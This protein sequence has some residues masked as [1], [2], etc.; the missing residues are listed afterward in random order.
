M[1]LQKTRVTFAN[2]ECHSLFYLCEFIIWNIYRVSLQM[3]Y[4]DTYRQL[5]T[6]CR[7]DCIILWNG[8]PS[9]FWDPKW[10]F[11][12]GNGRANIAASH[13][14]CFAPQS[15]SNPL[16]HMATWLH[17]SAH[18]NHALYFSKRLSRNL[19][20]NPLLHTNI[21]ARNGAVAACA[22]PRVL[23]HHKHLELHLSHHRCSYLNF[24]CSQRSNAD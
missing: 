24:R 8:N 1:K 2:C 3:L 13:T 6:V 10:T 20:D 9:I 7:N 21:S 5:I 11:T 4:H 23:R 17:S 15:R 22:F 16:P 12:S 19:P 18:S 14:R